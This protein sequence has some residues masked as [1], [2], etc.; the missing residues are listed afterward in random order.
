MI[1][2]RPEI[3]FSTVNNVR[4]KKT[5]SELV[6]YA[7]RNLGPKATVILSDRL[8]DIGFQYS[9]QGGLSISIDAMIIPSTKWD[10]LKKAE[11]Q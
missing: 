11:K 10:I 1:K 7:Y 3:P 2:K 4:D 9:T 5:L 8:K 6:N